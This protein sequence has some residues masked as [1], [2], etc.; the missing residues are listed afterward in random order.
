[1]I[2][3]MTKMISNHLT[4]NQSTK[5]KTLNI[6]V[7]FEK[8]DISVSKSSINIIDGQIILPSFYDLLKNIAHSKCKNKIVTQKVFF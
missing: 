4:K 3:E 7:N 1:M 5:V 2:E 6:L 8:N